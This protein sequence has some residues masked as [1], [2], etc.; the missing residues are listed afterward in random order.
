MGFNTG[1][2][3]RRQSTH[4]LSRKAS[5]RPLRLSPSLF[6][7]AQP[8]QLHHKPRALA[9]ASSSCARSACPQVRC[10]ISQQPLR[11]GIDKGQPAIEIDRDNHRARGIQQVLERIA[12]VLRLLLRARR[13]YLPATAWPRRQSAENRSHQQQ[14]VVARAGFKAR[15]N[16]PRGLQPAKGRQTRTMSTRKICALPFLAVLRS[17]PCPCRSPACCSWKGKQHPRR[18]YWRAS[19][20]FFP[21]S[22]N[23]G[24]SRLPVND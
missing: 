19:S 11:G 9:G 18:Q 10:V 22:S 15:G 1:H 3:A 23:L 2:L 5:S 17:S 4:N 13:S 24:R 14:P 8:L 21:D 20:F 7:S 6:D 16:A 12:G